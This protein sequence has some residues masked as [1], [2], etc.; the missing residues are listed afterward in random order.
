LIAGVLIVTALWTELFA[1]ENLHGTFVDG[2]VE[3]AQQTD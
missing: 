3:D 2:H 1:P